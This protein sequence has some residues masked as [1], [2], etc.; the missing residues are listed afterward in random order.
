MIN[1]T[2]LSFTPNVSLESSERNDFLLVDYVL[3]KPDSPSQVHV[4]DGIGCLPGVL[5]VNSQM[6]SLCL[7]S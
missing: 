5:E 4:L 2:N 7:G 6:R 1:I 3:Q